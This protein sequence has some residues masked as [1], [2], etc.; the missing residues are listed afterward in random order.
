[1]TKIDWN[2]RIDTD[3]LH[4]DLLPDPTIKK[5]SQTIRIH[6]EMGH[7]SLLCPPDFDFEGE[8]VQAWLV[9]AIEE[10]IRSYAKGILP[11]R[12]RELSQEF[13]LPVKE[14]HVN[15]ARGRWGS[16]VGRTH[17]TLFHS[18]TEYT[19]NFSFF[20]LLLPER[21]QRLILLHELTHTLEMNH[22]PRFHQKLDAMLG[23]DEKKLVRELKSYT[24][25]I[26]SFCNRRE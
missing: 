19:I 3:T 21:L 1:M 13:G 10:Q 22:S 24:T 18:S 2:F 11:A 4:I 17:R 8:G 7:V 5:G 26:F 23:G 14:V 6:K 9:K 12:L 16:C 15:G 20:T 25:S